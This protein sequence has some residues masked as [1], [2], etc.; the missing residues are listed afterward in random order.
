MCVEILLS[1]MNQ[2]DCS[3]LKEENISGAATVI[4]QTN[5]TKYF[6]ITS[7]PQNAKQE[8]YFVEERGLSKSRNMAINKASKEICV[9]AD[10]D[11]LFVDNYEDVIL[12]AFSEL[13]EADV[14][15]FDIYNWKNPLFRKPTKLNRLFSLKISSIQIA[16]RRKSIIKERIKFDTRLGAGSGNGAGEENKFIYDCFNAGL[17]IYY[18]PDYI[19]T[20]KDSKSTWF[21]GYTKTYFYD[22]GKVLSYIYGKLFAFLYSIYFIISKYKLFYKKT[23]LTKAFFYMVKGINKGL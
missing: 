5:E 4:N 9:F 10:D 13:Q 20:L 14:I 2:T 11:E 19:A 17:K 21:N 7:K 6:D 16:F 15:I 23:K 3:I 22:K 8:F 12:K 18:Y 1:C